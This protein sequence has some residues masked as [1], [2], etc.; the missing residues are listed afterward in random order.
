[1][2]PRGDRFLRRILIRH[3]GQTSYW[4]IIEG[5]PIHHGDELVLYAVDQRDD[6]QL[7]ALNAT[8]AATYYPTLARLWPDEED[9]IES[10]LPERE[11]LILE[12]CC[13]GGRITPHLLRRGNRVVGVDTS[14]SCVA[15]ARHK[16]G[17][18]VAYVVGDTR[19]LP[20]A[21][22]AFDGVCCLEN[23]LGVLFGYAPLALTE[24]VR[25][26]RSGGFVLVGLR[27]Q[28]GGARLHLYHT[29]DGH[30]EAARTFDDASLHQLLADVPQTTRL[31]MGAH[32]RYQGA[33]RPWGGTTFYLRFEINRT[34]SL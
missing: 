23:S 12:S 31:H 8:F 14:A 15:A 6:D 18:R 27:R 1:M 33:A 2:L 30:V 11:A 4:S 17:A 22:E 7:L 34:G 5:Q 19:R 13:G 25:V 9:I 10:V 3:A 21:D 16:D 32:Q 24:L 26:T 28:P 29:A 20:F